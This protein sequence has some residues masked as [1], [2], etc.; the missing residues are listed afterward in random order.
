MSVTAH[1]AEGVAQKMSTLKKC[2]ETAHR[3]HAALAGRRPRR[4][5]NQRPA[6]RCGIAAR[7]P[8][9][10]TP[11]TTTPG[12]G[13]PATTTCSCCGRLCIIHACQAIDRHCAVVCPHHNHGRLQMG[14]CLEAGGASRRVAGRG[15]AACKGRQAGAAHQGCVWVGTAGA[16]HSPG[17]SAGRGSA[18]G[19]LSGGTMAL[20]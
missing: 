14:G 7:P 13:T 18:D 19:G 17:S 10:G 11:A 3:R 6:A 20:S 9:A 15:R 16:A 4:P 12:A 2:H 5:F 1:A 8:G